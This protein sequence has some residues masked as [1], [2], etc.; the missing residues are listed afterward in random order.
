MFPAHNA[1]VPERGRAHP[2]LRAA[3]E[4]ATQRAAGVD[5]P[6][7]SVVLLNRLGRAATEAA[8]VPEASVAAGGAQG[9]GTFRTAAGQLDAGTAHPA[10]TARVFE[11]VPSRIPLLGLV[12]T[13]EADG[14]APQLAPENVSFIHALFISVSETAVSALTAELRLS[15]PVRYHIHTGQHQGTPKSIVNAS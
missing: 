15:A 2:V 7:G 4:G 9:A 10:G 5:R 1:F 11:G 13:K 14:E 3:V 6:D 12:P 8:A